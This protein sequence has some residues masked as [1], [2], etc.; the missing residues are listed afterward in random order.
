MTQAGESL[1]YYEQLGYTILQRESPS[2]SVGAV[3]GKQ[4]FRFFVVSWR[5][6][7]TGA[8]SARLSFRPQAYQHHAEPQDPKGKTEDGHRGQRCLPAAGRAGNCHRTPT[9]EGCQG[10]RHVTE[11]DPYPWPETTPFASNHCSEEQ[12]RKRQ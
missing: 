10:E 7:L 5:G 11:N 2:H 3:A 8:A 4:D 12:A 9:E 1:V 6:N